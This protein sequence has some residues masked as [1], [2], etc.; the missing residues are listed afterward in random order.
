VPLDLQTI[1]AGDELPALTKTPDREALVK[2]AAGGG[3]F[4]P[5]HFD[6]DFPQAV[7][8]GGNIVHG[9]LKYAALGELVWSWLGHAGW[10]RKITAQYRGIDRLNETFTC[11]GTVTEVRDDVDA[12]GAPVRI[13][14]LDVW[15]EDAAGQ[16]TT[17]GVAEVVLARP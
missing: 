11:R 6:A 1:A 10:I 7:E 13:A 17:K 8:I 16:V 12:A 14:V 3:D 5:L 15:T 4:N 2:Y 9:R